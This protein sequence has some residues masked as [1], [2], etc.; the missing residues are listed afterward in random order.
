MLEATETMLTA[1]LTLAV[2]NGERVSD[3]VVDAGR[4]FLEHFAQR[5]DIHPSLFPSLQASVQ[6]LIHGQSLRAIDNHLTHRVRTHRVFLE[7]V[8]GEG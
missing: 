1:F 5:G 6:S 8:G 2:F 4:Q 7:R 3:F